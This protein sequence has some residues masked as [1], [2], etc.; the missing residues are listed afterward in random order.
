MFCKHYLHWC[1]IIQHS[2]ETVLAMTQS[3]SSIGTILA[4]W[5]HWRRFCFD[6]LP[7][8]WRLSAELWLY[9][10]GVAQQ[11]SFLECNSHFGRSCLV[12]VRLFD[13]IITENVCLD[14]VR[15][16]TNFNYLLV[17]LGVR[18]VR[19]SLLCSLLVSIV[20][21][22]WVSLGL[23]KW[24]DLSRAKVELKS[25]I[26]QLV[27]IITKSLSQQLRIH[28]TTITTNHVV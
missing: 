5:R 20:N 14:I 11:I 26:L 13:R 22:Q 2:F 21:T 17:K 3:F 27:L 12:I 1:S 16:L 6:F 15:L 7:L 10:T 23:T 25:S 9:C 19:A 4:I 8:L 28:N 24:N 18:R